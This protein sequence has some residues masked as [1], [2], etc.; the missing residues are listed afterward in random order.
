MKQF[1]RVL[2]WPI[3]IAALAVLALTGCAG[4]GYTP[5][6]APP[7]FLCAVNNNVDVD[8]TGGGGL[9]DFSCS[10]KKWEGAETLHFKV[11]VK[12]YTDKPQRFKVNIFLDNG[13]AVGGLIP[14]KTA[15]GLV[16]PGKVASF[17]YPVKGVTRQPKEVMLKIRTID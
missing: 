2:I 3:L 1:K 9:T 5:D 8:V 13:K 17:T 12:N 6:N 4:K 14:R 16:E 15:K 10:F 11:A 7:E